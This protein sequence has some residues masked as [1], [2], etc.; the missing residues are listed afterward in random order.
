MVML[1]HYFTRPESVDRLRA[2]WLGPAIDRYSEWLVS[3]QSAKSTALQSL[4][5]LVDLDRFAQSRGIQRWDELPALVDDFARYRFRLHGK[6]CRTAKARRTQRSQSRAPVEQLLRL[7]IP[8]YVGTMRRLPWPFLTRAPGFREYLREERGLRPVTMRRYAHYLRGFE[9]YL[10]RLTGGELAELSPG[11]LIKFLTR[12]VRQLQPGGLQACS[13]VLRVFLRYLHRQG[14]LPKDLSRAVPR[15]RTYR[16]A[17]IPRGIPWSEVERVLAGIDRRSVLGKRDY[18]MLLLL[19]TY[20]LRAQEVA[21]LELSAIDWGR[22]QLHVL[23]RKA[24]NSTSYPL[25]ASVGEAIIEYLRYG[26]PVSDDRYVFLTVKAPYHGLQHFDVSRQATT[27]LRRAGVQVSRPGSHTF[28]HSCV[29]RLVEADIPFK[30]ISDYVGHRS[31]DA[32]QVY[33]KVA[34]H[35]LRALTLGHAE[36]A[37]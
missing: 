22:S 20:G 2:L 23:G 1:E 7:L 31:P 28:R 14:I 29:Q 17:A 13:G 24:G 19:A 5:A 16:H 21:M 35:K 32:T 8:G 3:R 12:R 10:Q 33:A 15:G 18:A 30:M 34:L 27:Y 11:L 25:A 6:G 4:H 36:D 26:R 37:L 9:T